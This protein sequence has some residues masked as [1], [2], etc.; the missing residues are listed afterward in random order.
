MYRQTFTT[1]DIK[2]IDIDT[3]TY[4]LRLF[5]FQPFPLIGVQ[6]VPIAILLVFL[7][8]N[9]E[10]LLEKMAHENSNLQ[11]RLKCA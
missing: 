5:F 10:I 8:V 6:F 1:Y 3:C 7:R 9:F 11:A 2:R 4:R